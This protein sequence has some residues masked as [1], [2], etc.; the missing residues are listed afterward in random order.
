MNNLFQEFQP[1][2]TKEW[3]EIIKKDLKGA[4]LKKLMRKTIDELSFEPFYRKENTENLP[5]I[6]S[7]SGKFPFLRGY[8]LNNDWAI[9]QDFLF[10]NSEIS[11]QKAVKAVEKGINIVGFN[12]GKK[13][14][15]SIEDLKILA[16]NVD[17]L[18]LSAYE[19]IEDA[20]DLIREHNCEKE[21]FLNFDPITYHAFTGGFYKNQNKTWAT[22]SD[23]LTN[24][25]KNVKP[26]GINLHH[27]ANAGATP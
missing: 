26:V 27:Y 25:L 1:T 15:L 14:D 23:L 5:T 19:N 24:E 3:L 11:N 21:I 13:F 12:F 4:D 8:K 2:T 10:N 22:A 20:Y 9:R 7:V 17:K 16:K 18:A 6:D